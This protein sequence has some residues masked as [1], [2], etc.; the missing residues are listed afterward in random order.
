MWNNRSAPNTSA[1][2]IAAIATSPSAP[3]A[4]GRH[5]CLP[6]SRIFVRS[7]TPA[8]VSR[9]AHRDR[10]PS[11]VNCGLVNT[12]TLAS[13][14]ISRNPSTKRGN[15]CHRNRT[16]L[17]TR[18]ACPR[19]DQYNAYPSTT[20]PI[21]ALRVVF[22]STANFPATSEYSAPAAV[23]SAVLSTAS[24][25][26]NPYAWSPRCRLCPISGNVNS[27]SAPSARIAAIAVDDSSSSAS[28]APCVAMI[29]DTPH[30]AD[31]TASSEVNFGF[32]PNARPSPCI[33]ASASVIS[34][35][36][37]PRLIPPSRS[38]SPSRKRDPSSTIPTFSQKSYVAT[39]ATNTFGNPTVF[40]S[41]SPIRIA[42]NTYSIFG[43]V[44]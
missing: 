38:T 15:F 28:I 8:N 10:L 21:I 4:N 32:N 22:T 31:P 30:T 27:D 37:N 1:S 26:H 13:S 41:T 34:I 3:I 36:T 24:P 29:A 18:C 25:A 12:A 11:A 14:E 17:P 40:A 43:S 23:A 2:V 42:H 9:N 7:P 5:P 16:L 6:S 44:R 19:D 35:A 33:N 20:K 39:P